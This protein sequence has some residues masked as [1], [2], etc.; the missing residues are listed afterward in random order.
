[1]R[2]RDLTLYRGRDW[3]LCRPWSAPFNAFPF[4]SPQGPLQAQLRK[5]QQAAHFVF[6]PSSASK[7]APRY[8]NKRCRFLDTFLHC[9]RAEREGFEWRSHRADTIWRRRSRAINSFYR[10]N[11]QNVSNASLAIDA[12]QRRRRYGFVGCGEG[13]HSATTNKNKTDDLSV[14]RSAL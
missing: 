13:L 8:K 2:R 10:L 1:M 5:K 6:T 9:D 11:P 3:L 12:E 4:C 14:V 7:L